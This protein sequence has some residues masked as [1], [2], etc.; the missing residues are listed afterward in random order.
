M[1][2]EQDRI[3]R[4]SVP[5]DDSKQPSVAGGGKPEPE[6]TRDRDLPA[7]H[8]PADAGPQHRAARTQS[9]D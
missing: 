3:E 7:D 5:G 8:T 1:T 9:G 2:A 6:L 4:G